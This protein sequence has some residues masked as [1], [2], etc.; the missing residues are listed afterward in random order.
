MACVFIYNYRIFITFTANI[1][2][3]FSCYVM[4]CVYYSH[5]SESDAVKLWCCFEIEF[6]KKNG[7]INSDW[8]SVSSAKPKKG[9]MKSKEPI[10][11]EC[12][13]YNRNEHVQ[14]SIFQ[15]VPSC[16]NNGRENRTPTYFVHTLRKRNQ[17]FTSRR[18]IDSNSND[19]PDYS[20]VNWKCA[21][22]AW[23]WCGM[24]A[25]S[26]VKRMKNCMR[27]R[28]NYVQTRNGR[29]LKKTNAYHSQKRCFQVNKCTENKTTTTKITKKRHTM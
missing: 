18:T 4:F 22:F 11:H 17:L 16:L 23:L 1:L 21:S 27:I 5:I 14:I 13:K 15:V 3:A 24:V 19:E 7:H 10:I 6:V 20:Y 28:I 8:I 2:F 26:L 29:T 25:Q 12:V 9:P